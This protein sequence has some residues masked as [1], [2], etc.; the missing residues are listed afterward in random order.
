MTTMTFSLPLHGF[1]GQ[2]ELV[3]GIQFAVDELADDGAVA[4]LIDPHFPLP[5]TAVEFLNPRPG[6]T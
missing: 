5:A 3:F 1:G 6:R 4:L 2:V